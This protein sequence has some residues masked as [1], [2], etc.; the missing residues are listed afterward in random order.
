[1]KQILVRQKAT[2]TPATKQIN[3][4]IRHNDDLRELDDQFFELKQ[5]VF[6]LLTVHY[7]RV[8][9]LAEV[10]AALHVV[11]AQTQFDPRTETVNQVAIKLVDCVSDT[12]EHFCELNEAP[13]HAFVVFLF[14][15]NDLQIGCRVQVD[16]VNECS[17]FDVDVLV[18][19]VVNDWHV[20]LLELT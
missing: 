5:Q 6:V 13:C 2:I 16:Q 7:L 12:A 1:M 8:Q 10:I 18:V 11:L 20:L 19:V 17:Q 3:R 9:V 15:L 4:I 14:L